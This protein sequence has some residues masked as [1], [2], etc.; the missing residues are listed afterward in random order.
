MS[1][2]KELT[3]DVVYVPREWQTVEIK[4]QYYNSLRET[5]S[6]EE[7]EEGIGRTSG[8]DR[9]SGQSKQK[10]KKSQNRSIIPEITEEDGKGD[11][12]LNLPR[13]TDSR[14]SSMSVAR[15]KLDIRTARVSRDHRGSSKLLREIVVHFVIIYIILFLCACKQSFFFT[16]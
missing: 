7:E 15:N 3:N 12:K 11:S 9:S 6:D 10:V 16:I 8:L 5:H 2:W 13:R 14:M 1:T 4:E